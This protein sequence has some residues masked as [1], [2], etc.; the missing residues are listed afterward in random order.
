MFI[1]DHS[2][3]YLNICNSLSRRCL[4]N[5]KA[6]ASPEVGEVE[7]G[8]VLGHDEATALVVIDD[9]GVGQLRLFLEHAFSERTRKDEVVLVEADRL[10]G[11]LEPHDMCGRRLL[12]LTV[13]VER[14][15]ALFDRALLDVNSIG[16]KEILK[17]GHMRLDYVV[18]LLEQHGGDVPPCRRQEEVLA[19]YPTL[20]PMK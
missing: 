4:Y 9:L 17:T 10:T 6:Q 2:Q 1:L 8:D 15:L 11:Q 20:L 19:D 12:G 18:I 3:H 5:S 16:I 14:L 7:D 13:G